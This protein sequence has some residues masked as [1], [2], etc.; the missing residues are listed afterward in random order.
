MYIVICKING[1]YYCGKRSELYDAAHSYLSD[2][3]FSTEMKLY[4][5]RREV[6]RKLK[7][8][9]PD[10]VKVSFDLEKCGIFD[11]RTIDVFT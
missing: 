8:I 9:L 3:V 1:G 2:D 7:Q 11:D 4:K 6:I 5:T 10:V